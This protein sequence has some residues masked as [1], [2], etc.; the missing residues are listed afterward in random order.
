[1]AV[2]KPTN[3]ETAT[4]RLSIIAA[5]AEEGAIEESIE[6]GALDRHTN[7]SRSDSRSDDPTVDLADPAARNPFANLTLETVDVGDPSLID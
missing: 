7:P 2:V 3:R 5:V 6:D 4:D 1:M